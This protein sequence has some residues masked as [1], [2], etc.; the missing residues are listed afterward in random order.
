V[1]AELLRAERAAQEI[2]AAHIQ[3]RGSLGDDPDEDVGA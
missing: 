1:E 3:I 2:R